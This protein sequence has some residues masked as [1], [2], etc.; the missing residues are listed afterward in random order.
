MQRNTPADASAPTRR[1][2]RWHPAMSWTMGFSNEKLAAFESRLTPSDRQ[3]GRQ[4]TE[5]CWYCEGR[6]TLKSKRS[7][8]YE[9]FRALE[10]KAARFTEPVVVVHAHPEVVEAV[11]EAAERVRL[12]AIGALAGDPA[13][14]GN[15]IR[16]S[17]HPEGIRP[18]VTN[19]VAAATVLV[20]RLEREVTDRPTDDALAELRAAWRSRGL[21]RTSL[22][23][24]PRR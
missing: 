20:H 12:Q 1:S 16:L 13:L 10:R 23:R 2:R 9:I 3:I 11:R 6:G 18:M 19:W 22:R 24:E 15:L 5:T 14:A 4:M 17:L 21:V 7:V 8:V